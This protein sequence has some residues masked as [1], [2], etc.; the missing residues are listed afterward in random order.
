MYRAIDT[1]LKRQVAITVLPAS[2]AGDPERLMR[3]QREA[4]VVARLNH[5]NIAAIHEEITA[6]RV[7]AR[8][9]ARTPRSSP[10]RRLEPRLEMAGFQVSI[11]GRFGVST[12]VPIRGVAFDGLG[13]VEV[14]I[15]RASLALEFRHQG[16]ESL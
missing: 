3:F 11:N 1:N 10:R 13:C 7:R 6:V 4:E 12:Q 9:R 15:K 8:P 14:L 16:F 5:P 2:L